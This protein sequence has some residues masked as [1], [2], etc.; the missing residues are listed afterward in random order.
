MEPSRD[1]LELLK[2]FNEYQVE[3]VVVGAYALAHHGHPRYT[4]DLD[5]LVATGPVNAERVVRALSAF[6]FTSP[7]IDRSDFEK[8]GM[9]IRL[10]RPP[11]QVDLLTKL[12]GIEWR[13]VEA[14]RSYGAF[15]DVTV[16]YIG[17][18]EL[19]KAKRASG[20]TQDQADIEALGE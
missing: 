12:E 8:P 6:G 15:G 4:G 17:R 20:R 5:R 2:S 9:V 11:V 10:G 13:E 16:S 7:D 3:Y 18:A 14:N 1:F 19:V